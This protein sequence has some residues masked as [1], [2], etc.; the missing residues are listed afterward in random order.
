MT[1]NI[2]VSQGLGIAFALSLLLSIC[3][4][5]GA[6]FCVISYYLASLVKSKKEVLL[7]AELVE[8]NQNINPPSI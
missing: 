7:E 6:V 8:D 5:L 1:K 2:T 4:P 3:S